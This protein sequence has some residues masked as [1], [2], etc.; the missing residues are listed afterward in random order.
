M[1]ARRSTDSI[2]SIA[3]RVRSGVS[4][5]LGAVGEFLVQLGACERTFRPA[6]VAIIRR[7]CQ[8][9]AVG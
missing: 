9:P 8:R 4:T 1:F 5:R 3:W 6:A 2:S 7:L